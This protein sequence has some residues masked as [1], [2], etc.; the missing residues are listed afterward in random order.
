MHHIVIISV[1]TLALIGMMGLLF[2]NWFY[3]YQMKKIEDEMI[4]RLPGH[5]ERVLVFNTAF[6]LLGTIFF[7]VLIII[8]SM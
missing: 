5:L 1:L 3:M 7:A 2:Y 6:S 8:M 4:V